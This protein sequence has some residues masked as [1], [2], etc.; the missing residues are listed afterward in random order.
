MAENVM[1]LRSLLKQCR[2]NGHIEQI[3]YA[4]QSRNWVSITDP[5]DPMTRIVIRVRLR[6]DINMCKSKRYLNV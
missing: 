3:R 6:S 5:D 1:Q 4:Y 2:P